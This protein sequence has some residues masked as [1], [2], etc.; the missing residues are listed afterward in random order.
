MTFGFRDLTLR[1]VE[2]ELVGA[3][4]DHEHALIELYGA[5]RLTS[6]RS[7]QA[8]ELNRIANVLFAWHGRGLYDPARNRDRLEKHFTPEYIHDLWCPAGVVPEYVAALC[9]ALVKS[10][11]L[12]DDALYARIRWQTENPLAFSPASP[13]PVRTGRPPDKK[14]GFVGGIQLA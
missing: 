4:I 5:T 8:Y 14:G 2:E 11:E 9:G 12:F 6:F 3:A 10:Y 1:E 13:Q 7:E